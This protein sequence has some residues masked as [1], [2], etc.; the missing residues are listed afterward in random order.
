MVCGLTSCESYSVEKAP[1]Y[2]LYSSRSQVACSRAKMHKETR[3]ESDKELLQEQNCHRLFRLTDDSRDATYEWYKSQ[4]K[5]RAADTCLWF[6]KNENFQEWL[7]GESGVLLVSA[8]PGCGKSVLAKYLIEDVLPASATVCYFFFK[9]QDQNTVRQALCA[10]LHQL[11]DQNR[12][13]I[14]HALPYFA[15]DGEGLINTTESLWR[16]LRGATQDARAGSV[17]VVL[18]ALDECDKAEFE[19][20]IHNLYFSHSGQPQQT[21][22][23]YLLTSRPYGNIVSMFRRMASAFTTVHIPGSE[24]SD[25]ISLEITNVIQQKVEQ[26]NLPIAAKHHLLSRV[27]EIPHRTYLWVYLIFDYLKDMEEEG[28]LHETPNGVDSVLLNLPPNVN[29]AYEKILCKANESEFLRNALSVILAASRPLTLDELNI[30]LSL[31]Q[32]PSS[33]R[34]LDLADRR[35]FQQR[36]QSISRLFISIHHDRVYLIH[37]TAREFL[38]AST[39]SRRETLQSSSWQGTFSIHDVHQVIAKSCIGYL[40]LFNVAVGDVVRAEAQTKHVMEA[41][42]TVDTYAFLDYSAKNWGMHL[43]ESRSYGDVALIYTILAICDPMS[44]SH[45]AWFKIYHRIAGIW[46]PHLTELM[47]AAHFGHIAV[48]EY[49]LRSGGNV[50]C[51]ERT[52]RRTPLMYAAESGHTDATVILLDHG[53]RL[54]SKDSNGMNALL[55]AASRGRRDTTE[56]L[57]RKGTDIESKDRSAKTALSMATEGGHLA[58]V[59]LLVES[60]ADIETRD[61]TDKTPLIYAAAAARSDVMTYLIARGANVSAMDCE[62]KGTL[63]HAIVSADS[64]LHDIKALI[65]GG[66][67]MNSRDAENMTPLHYTVRFARTDIAELLIANGVCVDTVVYRQPWTYGFLETGKLNYSVEPRIDE[68]GW[69]LTPLHYAAWAGHEKMVRFF[70]QHGAN[71]NALSDY[72]ETPIHLSL[73]RNIKGTEYADYWSSRDWK[74]EVTLDLVEPSDSEEYSTAREEVIRQ[75]LLVLDALLSHP[76]VNVNVHDIEGESALH[77]IQYAQY[78][79]NG[80]KELA[81]KLLARNATVSSRHCDNKTP[82]HLACEENDVDT[83]RLLAS[84]HQLAVC[85]KAGMNALHLASKHGHIETMEAI[86]QACTKHRV[87]LSSRRDSFRRNALHCYLE[88]IF[89][90]TRGVQLLLD[91]GVDAYETDL[92][93]NT[94]F[95]M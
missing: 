37:Q 60:N 9:E 76:E 12:D 21:K 70:L 74:V 5:E 93:G 86:I 4:V 67:N 61:N 49:L 63:H 1:R 17:I 35:S 7:E 58:T 42:A 24:E 51:E 50:E 16:I 83:V 28:Q 65:D 89:P 75:R 68:P 33:M 34:D 64:E 56:L 2:L 13:L 87:D 32:A 43:R 80:S 3:S 55:F 10:V 46:P 45:Q 39:F 11:F 57:L 31:H 14:Q 18:D 29:A 44:K 54:V 72:G 6:L 82:L 47:I 38:L 41:G 27:Q 22:L 94:P 77:K 69:G 90:S 19:N 25:A 84:E 20:L 26:L 30:A 85:D 62:R 91:Y 81:M 92:D 36:I 78:A 79:S 8:D 73:A 88:S 71:P 15:K 40:S 23:R 66:A 59:E 53:A 48:V 95:R 52:S